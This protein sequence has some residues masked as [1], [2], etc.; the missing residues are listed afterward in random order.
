MCEMCDKL[1]SMV[2][3]LESLF[4]VTD[5]RST[6]L[7]MAIDEGIDKINTMS[8]D[9]IHIQFAIELMIHW[10]DKY[11]SDPFQTLSVAIARYGDRVHAQHEE[12]END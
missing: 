7:S 6:M 2:D 12:T 1:D 10:A 8:D 11:N 5:L 4:S 3:C 9:D